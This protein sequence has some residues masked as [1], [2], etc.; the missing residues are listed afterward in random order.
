MTWMVFQ[1][2]MLVN[3]KDVEKNNFVLF[4]MLYLVLRYY[5]FFMLGTITALCHLAT[6]Y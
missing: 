1:I 6:A 5:Y 4:L 2:Y 3:E